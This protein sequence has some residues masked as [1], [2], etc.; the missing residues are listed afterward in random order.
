[1]HAW[2][3]GLLAMAKGGVGASLSTHFPPLPLLFL[4]T[5]SAPVAD[6]RVAELLS[7]E[8]R[9]ITKTDWYISYIAW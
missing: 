3:G 7:T 1:M 4:K 2:E 9:A 8:N 5:D 6:Q